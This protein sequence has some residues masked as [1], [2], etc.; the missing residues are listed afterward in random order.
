M[1]KCFLIILLLSLGFAAASEEHFEPKAPLTVAWSFD[2]PLG[3]FDR[4]SIQRGLKVYQQ[5]CAACHSLSK[6]SFRHLLDIGFA[7]EDAKAI[8]S[9]YQVK[10]GPDDNG[11][12]YE[13]P[14]VLSDYFTSPYPNRQ[15]AEAANNGAYPPDLSLIAR[16]R[17]GGANYLYSLLVGFTGDES[18]DGLYY[19]PYFSTGKISMAPP[20]SDELVT[21][22]DGTRAT[23]EQMAFDVVNFLH[24]TAEHEMEHR[25]KLGL[26]V[27]TF[28]FILLILSWISNRRIWKDI[29]EIN[30]KKDGS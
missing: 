21:Y 23:V 15:A 10:D 2:G 12:Y 13:R 9:D 20:L 4:Q 14:G 19:N 17:M 7:E 1:K 22:D 11:E 3:T 5:V 16:G 27:M 6:I 18:P 29:K 26:K 24:W 25:K 8:A 28:L 30:N